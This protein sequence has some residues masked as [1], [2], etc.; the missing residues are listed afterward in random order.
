MPNS[1]DNTPRPFGSSEPPDR[2]SLMADPFIGF[3]FDDQYRIVELLGAGGW[4]NVYKATDLSTGTE[5]AVKVVHKH[6]LQNEMSMKRFELEAKLLSRLENRY[7]VKIID[8][9]FSPAPYIVME[10]FDGVPLSKW[11]KLNGPMQSNMAIDLFLQLCDGLATAQQIKI[12][13]RDLKPANILLKTDGSRVQAKI[14]DFGLAKFVDQSVGADKLTSTGDV[15]GSPPYMSPE[16]W[17][18]QCDHRSDIYSLGCIMYE[19]LAGQPAFTAAYGMDYLN[20][21]LSERPPNISDVNLREKFPPSLEDIVSKC[22]QKAP[23]NRYQSATACSADLKKIKIGRKPVV[24][25]AEDKK[26]VKTKWALVASVLLVTVLVAAYLLKEP[27][28]H[29]LNAY[30]YSQAD[31]KLS[32]GQTEDAIGQYRQILSLSQMLPDKDMQKLKA[33]HALVA[34]LRERKEFRAADAM[35]KQVNELIGAASTNPGLL[36]LMNKVQSSIEAKNLPEAEKQAKIALEQA[37]SSFGKHSLAYS[38][39]LDLLGTVACKKGAFHESV[40]Y[41]TEALN[42]AQDLLEQN[43]LRKADIMDHLAEALKG[44]GNSAESEKYSGL[45]LALRSTARNQVEAASNQ[46]ETGANKSETT[47]TEQKDPSKVIG[48]AS[49]TAASATVPVTANPGNQAANTSTLKTS[50]STATEIAQPIPVKKPVVKP[51]ISK[52]IVAKPIVAKPIVAKPVVAKTEPPATAK[53]AKSS[54]D[55]WGQL[56]KLRSVK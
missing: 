12:V 44:S 53:P 9:G 46:N 7:I 15:L 24:I 39:C 47:T 30:L 21:H 43:D 22:M 35:E 19:V 14:L 51:A 17:K 5:L 1:S 37:Q 31:S 25:L 32:M 16:Q 41:E 45:S 33:L 23:A 54:A 38:S 28:V 3:D 18:G 29:G 36:V 11:L 6:H 4:G 10:Y 2:S 42:I 40:G 34:L 8:H 26:T 56:E 52:P 48:A 55:P 13:H 49:T 27:I 20:K 50:L